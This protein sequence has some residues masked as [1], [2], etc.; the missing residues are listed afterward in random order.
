MREAERERESKRKRKNT[1][2]IQ[3]DETTATWC[4]LLCVLCVDIRSGNNGAEE[5]KLIHTLSLSLARSL[6]YSSMGKRE[7][8]RERVERP[9]NVI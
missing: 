3:H 9:K 8:E 1:R 6:A 2:C 7:R 4:T 5:E